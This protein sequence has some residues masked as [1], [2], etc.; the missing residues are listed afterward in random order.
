[1]AALLAVPLLIA[2]AGWVFL[3][4]PTPGL[5][6]GNARLTSTEVSTL[7]AV[8]KVRAEH[9]LPKVVVDDRLV[10]AARSHSADMVANQYFDHGAFANRLVDLGERGPRVGE[11]LGWA[12][13]PDPVGT[14]VAE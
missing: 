11:D 12:A 7:G 5:A 13:G 6:H 3:T 1:V 14:I 4:G 2:I 10:Q 9:G 8:N